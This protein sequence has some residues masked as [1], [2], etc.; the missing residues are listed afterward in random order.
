MKNNFFKL[1][2]FLSCQTLPPKITP[3]QIP[4]KYH[5]LFERCYP[6][7]DQ[8]RV[9]IKN[10]EGVYGQGLLDWESANQWHWGFQ[11]FS[12]WG[13][14]LAVGAYENQTFK[15]SGFLEE[16]NRRVTKNKSDMIAF[17]DYELPILVHEVPC[18]LKMKWPEDWLSQNLIYAQD[19]KDS[20]EMLIKDSWRNIKILFNKEPTVLTSCVN[21]ERK[22]FFSFF[23]QELSLCQTMNLQD[24][25]SSFKIEWKGWELNLNQQKKIIQETKHEKRRKKEK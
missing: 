15:F 8:A 5:E 24:D 1:F 6:G 2:L 19:E 25:L 16:L 22:S 17:D 21:L 10:S 13:E 20:Y 14:A 4:K 7:S 11:I 3:D 23:S 12:P 18:L 9:T